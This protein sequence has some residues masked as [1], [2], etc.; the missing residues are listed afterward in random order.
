MWFNIAATSGISE[1]AEN[2]TKAEKKMTT[3]EISKAQELASQ[4]VNKNYKDC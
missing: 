2:R 1:A 3:T 4:C